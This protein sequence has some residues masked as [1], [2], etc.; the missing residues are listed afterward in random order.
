[1]TNPIIFV[2]YITQI[3]KLSCLSRQIWLLL[4][5]IIQEL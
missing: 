5:D 4:V 3:I 2:E 1:M